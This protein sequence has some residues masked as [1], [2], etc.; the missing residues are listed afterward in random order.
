MLSIISFFFGDW[1]NAR[2]TFRGGSTGDF[3]RSLTIDDSNNIFITGNTLS[4]NFPTY[5]TGSG[6]FYQ[7]TLTG[8]HE[9]FIVGFSSTG[10]RR[11]ATFYG[12]TSTDYGMS[13]ATDNLNN[14]FV[15]GFSLSSNFPTYNPGGSA[16][17]QGTNAGSYDAYILKFASASTGIEEH[18]EPLSAIRSPMKIFPNPASSYFVVHCPSSVRNIKI[19]DVTGKEVYAL[20]AL[21]VDE[22][23][24][25]LNDIKNGVY[26]IK[27]NN[28]IVKE[29]LVITK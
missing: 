21:W 16:Y 28:D 6:A 19:F 14:I 2:L 26:F 3:A 29:K 24:I 11:W 10:A 27:I 20:M 12:G 17:F 9:I 13:I 5:D 18:H 1:L 7:G 25:P 8:G 4:S 22:L 23:K 15:T